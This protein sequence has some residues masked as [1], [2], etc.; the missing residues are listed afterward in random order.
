LAEAILNKHTDKVT[1]VTLV[2]SSGGV[3]EIMFGDELIYSKKET[4]RQPMPND[5]LPKIAG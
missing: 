5:I 1:Q 4:G 2:P 3:H